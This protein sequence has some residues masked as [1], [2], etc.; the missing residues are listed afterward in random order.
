MNEYA[1]RKGAIILPGEVEESCRQEAIFEHGLEVGVGV[2]LAD[3]GWADKEGLLDINVD[4][5]EDR[6]GR[7]TICRV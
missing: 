1:Q 7:G 5:Q 3:K 6:A 2:S 4:T